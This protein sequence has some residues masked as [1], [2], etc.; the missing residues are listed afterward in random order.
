MLAFFLRYPNPLSPHVVTA[1]VLDQR[2]DP[3]TGKLRTTK[4]LL[5]RGALPRWAPRGIMERA[6]SWVLEESEVDVLGGQVQVSTRN[7]DHTVV[8]EV[9][10]TQRMKARGSRER[11][12]TPSLSKLR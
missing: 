4:L 5:K 2:L 3:N 7:I 9:V 10:E 8:L 6:E 12:S 11:V 1:D